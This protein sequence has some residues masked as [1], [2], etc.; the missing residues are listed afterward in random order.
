M[1]T[2]LAHK[3]DLD[4]LIAVRALESLTTEAANSFV[5]VQSQLSKED[6]Q[7]RRSAKATL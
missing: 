7:E 6:E 4:R 1:T 2:L 3:P 5:A